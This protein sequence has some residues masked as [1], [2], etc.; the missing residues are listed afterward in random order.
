MERFDLSSH[1]MADVLTLPPAPADLPRA[2]FPLLASLAPV[3]GALGLWAI[4]GSPFSLLF[5]VL[6]PL[7]A[8]A[9]MLD[10]RRSARRQRRKTGLER[11]LRLEELE[12]EV[13]QRHALERQAAWRRSP[14][15]RLVLESG[16]HAAWRD[17]EPSP[18]VLGR[19][20]RASIL[21]VDGSAVDAVDRELLLRAR[22]LRD[23]PIVV[24]SR[25]GVGFTGD[26]VLARAAARAAIVQFAH[27]ASP[28]SFAIEGPAHD[29]DGHWAWLQALPH[30]RGPA[31]RALCV[32][33]RGGRAGG[34]G[35]LDSAVD[36]ARADGSAPAR[37][38]TRGEH[39]AAAGARAPDRPFA[40]VA[41]ASAPADLPPGLATIVTLES[42]DTATL[43]RRD[44][45]PDE[46]F[47]PSLIG[48]AEAAS[49]ARAAGLAAARAGLGD[50]STQL[51]SRVGL[52]DLPR[53]AVAHRGRSSLVVAVG[54]VVG[55]VL[56]LDLVRGGPHALVAGTTGS[57]KSEFL[58]AWLVALA[59]AYRPTAVSF[60]LID[61]KGGAA[62]EPIRDLPHVTGIVTDLDEAEAERAVSSLRAEL[63]YREA[64]LAK[65]AARDIAELAADV[66]LARLVI[67]IDEFQA[68]I[69]RF[70]DIGAI[71]ADIAARGRSLGMH[72]VLA[73]QRPNGVVREQVTAN[74][75][76]RV[77]LRVMQRA[78]S[79]AV[80]ASPLAAE[81]RSDSPG[82]GVIDRGD[83]SPELFQSAMAEPATIA[84][85]ASAA[86][87][88]DRARRT[89]LD[90]LPTRI[91]AGD[92]TALATRA[93]VAALD[94]AQA[95]GGRAFA[96]QPAA[97]GL[98][99]GVLDEPE[100]QRRSVARWSPRSD[101]GLL[102]IGE[103]GSG[104]STA[105]ASIA[106]AASE[107]FGPGGVIS[108]DGPRSAVWDSILEV[109]AALRRGDAPGR[110]IL[111]DDLDARF[112]AWP[113]D[114]RHAAL[115]AI[116]TIL[117]EGRASGLAV[118]AS[119]TR[120][121]GL[122]AALRD[123]FG[124]RLLLRHAT[125][126][127][128]VQSGGR[129]ELWRS[130]DAPGAGQ[131]RDARVQLVHTEAVAARALPPV[132]ELHLQA[133]RP[134]AIATASPRAAAASLMKI[135][136]AAHVLT[137]GGEAAVRSALA[138]RPAD[139]APSPVIVGDSEAWAASWSLAAA[140]REE[141]IMVVHGGAA[142]YRALVRTRDL[143]PLLDDDPAQCWVI[144]PAR[145]VVRAVWPNRSDQ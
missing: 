119:A 72:L 84:A 12:A 86:A 140:L 110:V 114:Y 74:C 103:P 93:R 68:M 15:P 9:S 51:P 70:P 135:G 98:A 99:I 46:T 91:T 83:G 29:G 108:V 10:S 63:R 65:A 69:E 127:D 2:G 11:Q 50:R 20:V 35:A 62:F 76:I 132:P 106:R 90:P 47:S 26:L 88:V 27:L 143:P 131:W 41:V 37:G 92:V 55:G 94:G 23:A 54:A 66:D 123:G 87:G 59:A 18:I 8:I 42:P 21:R 118:A 28:K 1:P 38:D 58:L 49:W 81:I 61:F 31:G 30:R 57:G 75:A 141:A 39:A 116:E 145:A 44:G 52:A 40:L 5:A 64:V 22:L 79:E 25:A 112:R 33:D 3:V 104:R 17:E 121:H 100:L 14:S 13:E 134:Y 48:T 89:W 144:E 53:P 128:L 142:E 126:S 7:V 113:D 129:G 136:R 109:Q 24:D 102:V 82:R 73:S 120:L 130:T 138:A 85:I 45:A 36:P 111:I 71:V 34:A 19:G 125:R 122:G 56:E 97:E 124:S 43:R 101:G 96:Q 133:E 105:L 4:T 78:D 107:A 80:V 95:S 137:A 16:D 115:E 32:I 117:R 6:G 67:V 139:G 60:L 77:S